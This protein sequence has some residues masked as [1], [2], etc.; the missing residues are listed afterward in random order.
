MKKKMTMARLEQYQSIK[1]Q[2]I[3]FESDLGIS[4]LKGVDTSKISVQSGKVSRPAEDMALKLYEISNECES[5]YKRLLDEFEVLTKYIL[6]IKNEEVKE[7]AI[8]R[9]IAGQTYEQ[10]GD[11]I[12]CSRTTV[13]RKLKNYIAHNA[14]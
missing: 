1:R 3:I 5:E 12:F 4:Y 7:I 14:H 11:V 13:M 8:R 2:I 6:H 9:F 10:I